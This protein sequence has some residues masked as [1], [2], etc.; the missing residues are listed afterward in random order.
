MSGG[1]GVRKC[2]GG[3]GKCLWGNCPEGT[4]PRGNDQEGK[5][6]GEITKTQ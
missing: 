1:G 3:W 6:E 5:S 2:L 4:R